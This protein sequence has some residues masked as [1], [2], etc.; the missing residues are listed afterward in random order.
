MIDL[1]IVIVNYNTSALLKDCLLSVQQSEGHYALKTCVV[2]NASADDSVAMVLANFPDVHVIASPKNGGFAKANNMGLRYFGFGE[3]GKTSPRYALLLNPDTKLP[4]E[5]L[6]TMIAFMDATPQAGA[7]GP[8]LVLQ[9]GSLDYA[10][11][12]SFPTPKV[13]F[14]RMTGLSSLFPK[15]PEF[16]RYNMT[17]LD[18]DQFTEV[19]SVVGA[20]MLVRAEAIAQ[21][22]LMDETYFMYGED[23]DWAYNIKK[24]G[25]KIFYNPA[26]T[27]LHIKRASSKH[28]PRAQ[29][30]FY[31][32]M[33]I[34]YQKYYAETT[35][36][37][38][39]W[40]ITLGI[41]SKWVLAD[42]RNR[43]RA[44]N[45]NKPTGENS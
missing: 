31:R 17:F 35:P 14:Y 22:G 32:A 19:D 7:V 11:R 42:L 29:V 12:R 2:D 39:H 16:G 4:P 8:K 9:D 5:A 45:P 24:H 10:C 34:F 15:H 44:G 18:P 33:Q 20:F 23:I 21:A 40:L 36:F 27:V 25:W 28:S 37:W 41:R 30:E 26:A 1:A 13:S 43:M 38:L 6:S 3:G